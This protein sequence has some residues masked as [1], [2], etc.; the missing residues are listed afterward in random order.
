MHVQRTLGAALLS[1]LAL[2]LVIGGCVKNPVT[3]GRQLALINQSQEIAMGEAS[4]PE[5][6]AQFGMVQDTALQQYFSKLGA[7]LARVSHRPDLPWHFTIVDSPVVNAF[8]VPGG[9]VYITR[10]II[11]YMNNEA[12]LAGVVGHEIGHIT[13]RH[14]VTQLSQQQLFGL[15]LTL[16]SVFSPTFRQFGQLAQM[17]LQVL[18]L[19]YSRE[20]ER[21]ADELGIQ[22]MTK[23]G[24]DPDQMS[25]FFQVFLTMEEESGQAIPSW[26]SSHPTTT[27]RIK[28]TADYAARARQES[29]IREYKINGKEFMPHLEGLVYGENPREGFV[30]NGRFMHPDLRFQIDIPKGWKTQNTQSVVVFSEPSGGAV[31]QLSMASTE[32][33]QSPEAV[34]QSMGRVEGT[35]LLSGRAESINGNQAFLGQYSVQNDSETIS[36]LAAFI[37]YGG[38]IYQLAGLAPTATFSN[39]SPSINPVLRSFRELTD[40]K[41]LGRQ[42]DR[43]KMYYARKGETLRNLANSTGQGLVKVEDLAGIN[44]IDPDKPLE[45]GTSVKL[46]QPGKR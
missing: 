28:A 45:A 12:E 44:R 41:L 35:Q 5:V 31:V 21:Q 25:K 42:P 34:G 8:A 9:Y 46:V 39:Y 30:E 37:S 38:H 18:L 36:V 27:E 3:G 26:L 43:I 4:H 40:Q 19:K 24:Y 10:G 29:T 11:E 22:Y 32:Q 16:G 14:S 17:G 7:D 13:A 1:M 20:D 23:L 15:G 6:I 2:G 33:G